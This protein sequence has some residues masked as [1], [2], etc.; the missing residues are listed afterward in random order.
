MSDD[1]RQ[2]L[3]QMYHQRVGHPPT[4]ATI[5]ELD[6]IAASA[7]ARHIVA[8]LMLDSYLMNRKLASVP[9]RGIDELTKRVDRVIRL[10][11]CQTERDEYALSRVAIHLA[12][13]VGFSGL[14]VVATL[15]AFLISALDAKVNWYLVLVALIPIALAVGVAY[16]IPS[17]CR[18]R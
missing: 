9:L 6:V 17:A 1:V 14:A 7:S 12:L 15:I 13:V 2:A 11:S 8:S 4:G 10:R 18:N 16:S 5:R 3:D